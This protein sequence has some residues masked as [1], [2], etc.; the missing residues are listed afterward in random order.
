LVGQGFNPD[1][2]KCLKINAGFTGC[3]KNP[4]GG[5]P[6]IYPRH[7]ADQ[8]NEGFSPILHKL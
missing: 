1:C 5:M 2:R 8:I 6:G 4:P 3:G 7:K